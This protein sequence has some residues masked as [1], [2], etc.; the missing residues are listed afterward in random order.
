MTAVADAATIVGFA[1][2]TRILEKIAEYA[3]LPLDEVRK[4]KAE[5]TV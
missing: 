3:G 5:Q 2:F 1:L 4:L